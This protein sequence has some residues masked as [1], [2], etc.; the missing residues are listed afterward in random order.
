MDMKLNTL[1]KLL[2]VLET[3]E[4]PIKVDEETREKALLPLNRM[5]EL[6]K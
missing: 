2:K 4:N 1:D 3:E 6:A 5:L